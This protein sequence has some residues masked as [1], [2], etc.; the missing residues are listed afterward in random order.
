[1][2]TGDELRRSIQKMNSADEERAMN[3]EQSDS[4]SHSEV[5]SVSA[6]LDDDELQPVLIP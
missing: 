4:T 2:Y 5:Q 3:K 6:P 1:M